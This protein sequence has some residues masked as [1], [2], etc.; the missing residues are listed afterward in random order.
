MAR[1]D[2]LCPVENPS[3]TAIG[4]SLYLEEAIVYGNKVI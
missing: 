1:I 3:A 4:A 2:D